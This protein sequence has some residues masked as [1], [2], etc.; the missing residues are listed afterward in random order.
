MSR[1]SVD[2]SSCYDSSRDLPTNNLGSEE[3][4]NGDQSKENIGNVGKLKDD[5]IKSHPYTV[6]KLWDRDD[7]LNNNNNL[8]NGSI[9]S[10]EDLEP[11]KFNY[12]F[13]TPGSGV[14]NLG[15]KTENDD[16]LNNLINKYFDISTKKRVKKIKTL[17]KQRDKI[18]KQK[19][20][21]YNK[22]NS[23]ST[24]I[25]NTKQ[26]NNTKKNKN[27]NSN[28]NIKSK[29]LKHIYPSEIITEDSDLYQVS[30]YYKNNNHSNLSTPRN[31]GFLSRTMHK[32][33][34]NSN[35]TY[36]QTIKQSYNENEDS[37]HN[38]NVVKIKVTPRNQLSKKSNY[39]SS[40]P[41]FISRVKPI[42][43]DDKLY[44]D[45]R[46]SD[47][48]LN[49]DRNIGN[50][51]S[52]MPKTTNEIVPYDAS[53]KQITASA[54]KRKYN[55]IVTTRTTT[56][57]TTATTSKSGKNKKLKSVY[58]MTQTSQT[59]YSQKRNKSIFES[60]MIQNNPAL[61]P[62]LSLNDFNQFD[63]VN[64]M[65]SF[66]F[67]NVF[68][69]HNNESQNPLINEE[70]EFME[71]KEVSFRRLQNSFNNIYE[72]YGKIFENDDEIDIITGEI[73][74]DKGMLK[75]TPRRGLLHYEEEKRSRTKNITSSLKPKLL[76][77]PSTFNNS[78]DN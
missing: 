56:T 41:N 19:V 42:Y 53:S 57:T 17:I 21:K 28:V 40:S 54:K 24:R 61:K 22:N 46:D 6:L 78:K 35:I 64:L 37:N 5:S 25:N 77:Y 73:V 72:R 48:L 58:S 65:K 29:P 31:Y 3:S 50:S 32:S 2:P 45:L 67:D 13:T 10:Q 49:Q 7:D 11:D 63:N 27:P 55:L 59:Q 18:F 76:E 4:Y 1:F 51:P 23:I 47:D 70:L 33:P 20:N 75:S 39:F 8:Y 52:K 16:L 26:K 66:K 60:K 74:V 62:A 68:K 43:Y 14:D 30:N 36:T 44:S 71:R 38:S 15:L 69:N 34:K 9:L 12:V